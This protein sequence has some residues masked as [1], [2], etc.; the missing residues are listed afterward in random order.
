MRHAHYI[1]Y[2]RLVKLADNLYWVLAGDQRINTLPPGGGCKD[3][4]G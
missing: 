2:Q 4:C 1:L 3:F